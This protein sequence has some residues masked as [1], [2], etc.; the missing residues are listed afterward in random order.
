MTINKDAVTEKTFSTKEVMGFIPELSTRK[1]YYWLRNGV[2]GDRFVNVGQ[3]N[4]LEFTYE[5]LR[6]LITLVRISTCMSRMSGSPFHT[7]GMTFLGNAADWL[8]ANPDAED[9]FVS[10][11]AL[12]NPYLTKVPTSP[13]Y[14]KILI[15]GKSERSK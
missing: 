9:M 13:D 4:R 3:G 12:G 7:A 11:G 5:D 14:L 15:K 2:L 6:I 1:L 8:R 10:F